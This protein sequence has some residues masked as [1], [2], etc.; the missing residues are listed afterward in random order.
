MVLTGLGEYY[1]TAVQRQGRATAR[2]VWQ[3]TLQ[4]GLRTRQLHDELGLP[5]DACGSLLLAVDDAEAAELRAAYKCMRRDDLPVVYHSADPLGREF[6]GALE[7]AGDTGIDPVRFVEA[8]LEASGTCV[9]ENC[10]VYALEPE[11]TGAC[12]RAR[13]AT[14]HVGHVLLATNAYSPLL[15][16]AFRGRVL[17]T[18]AQVLLTAPSP[19]V[20]D[21]LCYANH[22]YEYFRQ[23]PDG[24]ILMG[25][26]RKAFMDVEIG[27]T[28][29]T[30]PGVQ[31]GLEG[32]LAA[33]FP[34]AARE[35]E[36]RWS[37][38]MGFTPHGLPHVGV[39]EDLPCVGYAVGF[40]GHGLGTGILVADELIATVLHGRSDGFFG[41]PRNGD[42]S[43]E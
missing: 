25:G 19:R 23:L 43:D 5:Y 4:N 15:H 2:S 3:L 11:G 8:M 7:Q 16:P 9:L 1:H 22:G 29:E 27:Y 30:T 34:E 12:V 24:R 42:Q 36:L 20:L 32:F 13:L 18:R 37:G 26:W 38:V 31:A 28:D 40:N 10:E 35:I 17:P 14:V 41:N 39:L 6:C 33:R 21:T